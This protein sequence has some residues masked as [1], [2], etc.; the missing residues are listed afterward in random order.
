MDR[1]YIS[2]DKFTLLSGIEDPMSDEEWWVWVEKMDWIDK[3]QTN[4]RMPVYLYSLTD[5]PSQN[6]FQ[7]ANSFYLVPAT[8]T[9][10]HQ[11][12]RLRNEGDGEVGT[13]R[14][15]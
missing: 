1:F 2:L 6:I 9:Q 7:Y 11:I 15:D 12:V 14:V 8:I 13:D 3:G 4:T 5:D 10:C